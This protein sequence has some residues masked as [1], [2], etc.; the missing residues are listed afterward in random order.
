MKFIIL[1]FIS[2]IL[3]ILKRMCVYICQTD[4]L[5]NQHHKASFIKLNCYESLSC[6]SD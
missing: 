3:F 1:K 4:T 5:Y 2:K 6:I